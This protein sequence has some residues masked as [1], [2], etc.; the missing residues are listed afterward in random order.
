MNPDTLPPRSNGKHPGGRP[1][2][3]TP[4][5]ISKLADAIADGLP[6]IYACALVGIN[7]E[8]LAAWQRDDLD[9]EFS[10][11]V[12]AAQ[13]HRMI[14]LLGRIKEGSPGWQ[15]AAWFLER[16]FPQEYCRPE[17]KIAIQHDV[18]VTVNHNVNLIKESELARLIDVVREV[19]A[20]ALPELLDAGSGTGEEP[21]S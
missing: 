21:T 1:T 6:D 16:R 15:G 8:T 3:K 13:A 18:S 5:L 20:E 19:E 12:K 10:G 11:I 9:G 14:G 17:L 7:R 2:K 4:E